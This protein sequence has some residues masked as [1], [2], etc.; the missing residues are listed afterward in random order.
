[1]VCDSI[2][3]EQA[4]KVTAR[5][6]AASLMYRQV[7]RGTIEEMNFPV[8]ED[9]WCAHWGGQGQAATTSEHLSTGIITKIVLQ[10]TFNLSNEKR[11]RMWGA[12]TERES[13]SIDQ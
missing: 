5:F 3:S 13:R 6:S 8:A 4:A 2:V 12:T 9:L 1:M 7:C 11:C 10:K